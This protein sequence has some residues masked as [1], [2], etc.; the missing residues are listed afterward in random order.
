MTEGIFESGVKL[1]DSGVKLF[2]SDVNPALGQV[3]WTFFVLS[4][5]KGFISIGIC[6]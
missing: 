3:D 2:G 5:R 6:Q 1:F 4:T